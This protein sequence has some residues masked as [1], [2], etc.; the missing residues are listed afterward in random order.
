MSMTTSRSGSSV[1]SLILAGMMALLVSGPGVGQEAC[2]ENAGTLGIQGLRCEGCTYSMSESGIEEARFRTEPQVLA[3]VRGLTQGDRLRAGD[4]IVAIDGALITTREG[5]D[6]L[7]GLRAGQEVVLR[8]RRSGR[9]EELRIAT[10]SACELVRRARDMEVEVERLDERELPG[11]WTVP[12]PPRPPAAAPAPPRPAMPELPPTLGPSGYL[13]LGIRCSECGTRNG[14]FFFGAPPEITSVAEGG[15]AAEAGLRIGDVILAI[16]EED[17]TNE[18]ARRF[19]EIEPGQRVRFTVR[20]GD[21]PRTV[22]LLAARRTESLP[23]MQR[24]AP[25]P[26]QPPLPGRQPTGDELRFQGSLGDISIEV[27]GAPVT[28]DRDESTGEIVIRTGANTIRLTR[29]GG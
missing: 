15:P 23:E 26:P 25:L 14:V 11:R 13:G 29:P 22:T 19:G 9:I 16:E 6:R 20:R 7:A 8:V 1:Q 10:G 28:V 2:D 21:T 4:R 17:I 18:G 12:L 5:S 24:E 3:V 27:R